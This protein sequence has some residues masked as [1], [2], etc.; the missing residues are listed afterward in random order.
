ML[1]KVP[2]KE[3]SRLQTA[4]GDGNA[5]YLHSCKNQSRI[6]LSSPRE[7]S[8][9]FGLLQQPVEFSPVQWLVINELI[10]THLTFR[11]PISGC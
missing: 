7:Q 4:E 3:H 10:N 1:L 2:F 11:V 5:T 8:R 9:V 6:E